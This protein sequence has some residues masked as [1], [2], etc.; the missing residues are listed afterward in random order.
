MIAIT[1]VISRGIVWIEQQPTGASW[2]AVRY[3]ERAAASLGINVSISKVMAFVSGA[4]IAGISGSLL[5]MQLGNITSQNFEPY[6]SLI[7]FALAILAKSRFLS[8]ALFAGVLTSFTPQS[9]LGKKCSFRDE[10]QQSRGKNPTNEPR[11]SDAVFPLCLN[12][13]EKRQL[14]LRCR[15]SLK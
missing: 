5:L 15:Q 7:I 12:V 6:A 3:S 11:F 10:K 1:F 9:P 14:V 4:F 2:F 8:G 13:T